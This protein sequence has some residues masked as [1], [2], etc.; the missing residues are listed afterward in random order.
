MNVRQGIF[1]WL[2]TALFWVLLN[3]YA[4]ASS[5]SVAVTIEGASYSREVVNAVFK[6]ANSGS[7]TISPEQFMQSIVDDALLARYAVSTLG[8]AALDKNVDVG[9]PVF[10]WIEGQ[11]VSIIQ[12]AYREQLAIFRQQNKEVRLELLLTYKENIDSDKAKRIL[13]DYGQVYALSEALLAEADSVVVAQY[14]LPNL[15][16]QPISLAEVYRRQNVQGRIKLHQLST[17]YLREQILL[18]VEHK[19]TLWWASKYSDLGLHGVDDLKSMV[20][21]RYY[22]QRLR[23]EMGVVLDMHDDNPALSA[24]YKEIT[25]QE[26][27]QYYEANK[28]KFKRI[29]SVVARHIQTKTQQDA[30]NA[31]ELLK[32][33]EVFDS[34]ARKL[35]IA[36]D[37][38]GAHPGSLPRITHEDKSQNWLKSVLYALPPGEL[39]KPIRSP[40]QAEAAVVWEVFMVDE[41]VESYFEADSET[42]RYLSRK[43]IAQNKLNSRYEQLKKSLHEAAKIEINDRWMHE[44]SQIISG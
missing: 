7:T 41:R 22:A 8:Q 32:R 16:P 40:V 38:A 42:V 17:A 11:Q 6:V 28:E 39:S 26:I 43:I 3:D 24:V 18:L 21:A 2:S 33:G 35:S 15:E 10:A 14:R 31:L 29:D 30:E 25:Q 20:S 27:N 13:Q 23:A 9:F 4:S 12:S 5:S 36:A 1:K 19:L 37:A 34:V 44:A